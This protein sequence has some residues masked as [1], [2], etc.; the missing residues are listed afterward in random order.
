[1]DHLG[2]L[3]TAS[4]ATCVR[5]YERLKMKRGY[6]STRI[7]FNRR[8]LQE[9]LTPKYITMKMNRSFFS[10][11]SQRL[12]RLIKANFLREEIRKSYVIINSLD[13]QLKCIYD[14]LQHFWS[15][16]ILNYFLTSIHEKCSYVEH[17]K[18][19][20][21]NKKLT[22]LRKSKQNHSQVTECNPEHVFNFHEPILNFTDTHFTD[23]EKDCL[24]LGFKYRPNIM[25]PHVQARN[26]ERLA[27]ETN[28]VLQ[29]LDNS[30]AIGDECITEIRSE[31]NHIRETNPIN[32][33]GSFN[34][35]VIKSI[36][37][38]ILDNNL[39][40]TKADKGNSVVILHKHHYDEKVLKFITENQFTVINPKFPTFIKTVN[41]VL[42]NCTLTISKSLAYQ[43]SANNTIIPRL[44]GLLKVHKSDNFTE[45]PIRPVVSFTNSPTYKLAKWLNNQLKQ[46]I[47]CNFSNVVL[48]STQLAKKIQNVIIPNDALLISL[49]VSNLFT[50]VPII[51]VTQIIKNK[52]NESTLSDCETV[53]L[54]NLLNLCLKQNF[55]TFNNTVYCQEDG[56]SM[57]SPL[58]PLLADIY[59]DFFENNHI[60]NN[61]SFSKHILYY[62]RYVDD[63]LLLWSGNKVQLNEFLT[64]INSVH[65]KIKFTLEIENNKS[66]NFL[67]LTI[68]NV[69]NRHHF[70]VYRKPSHTGVIIHQSSFHPLQHKLAALN[71]FINRAIDIPLTLEARET[72]FKIIKQIAQTHNISLKIVDKL[73]H[74]KLLK[75]LANN[76]YLPFDYTHINRNNNN[77]K[78]FSLTFNGPI[79]Y[80]IQ[81]IFSRHNITIAFKSRDTLGTLFVNNKDKIDPLLNPGVYQL[82]CECGL[83]YIGKTKRNFKTRFAE[84]HRCIRF[85]NTESLFAKHILET[86]HITDFTN[87][88][89]ILH[90]ENYNSNLNNFEILEILRSH[91]STPNQ[92]INSQI[93][94]EH[95][96][97]NLFFL[98][99]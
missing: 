15:F 31:L 25:S 39:I 88:F 94:Y 38:K 61:N 28:S 71:S 33:S 86:G 17:N 21:L 36:K 57:G 97:L 49:D 59:M 96:I 10:N 60:L 14:R 87:N 8:C 40:L 19:K 2:L 82:T 1:M 56:L 43:L 70:A 92:L 65:P 4:L 69:N 68:T 93:P 42:K 13:I 35:N 51:E 41:S 83:K 48:N 29:S 54:L 20:N 34:I 18:L 9:D 77:K 7:Y 64:I 80:K 3:S 12:I 32:I 45:M 63:I 22:N 52:L 90:V 6:L 76:A 78:Y 89:K 98:N 75:N 16:P 24:S 46:T 62:H 91:T 74:K 81:R 99:N 23:N 26:L 84:H 66:I 67:D 47:N 50:N 72:E 37:Q 55:F 58:S 44:Y 79:S 11:K 27:V 85:N 30:Q 73:I 5:Q 95:P 53:E